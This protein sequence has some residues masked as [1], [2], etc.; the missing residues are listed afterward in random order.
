[1]CHSLFVEVR[2]Q[3]VELVLSFTTW[4]LGTEVRSSDMAV[5]LWPFWAISLVLCPMSYG[6]LILRRKC[7]FKLQLPK[8]LKTIVEQQ[9]HSTQTW[10]LKPLIPV[11]RRQT[12]DCCSFNASLVCM[13]RSRPARVTG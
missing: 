2:G 7:N 13:A 12:T 10:W 8:K 3:L 9:I 5:G 11:V 6:I 4:I 1:M